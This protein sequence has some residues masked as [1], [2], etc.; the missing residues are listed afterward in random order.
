MIILLALLDDV[1][2]MTIAYDRTPLP[3]RP[4]R[5][6]MRRLLLESGFMGLLSIVQTFGLLIIGMEWV[7]NAQWQAWITLTQE[8]LQT[9]I[10]L[11]LV[12]GGH[13]LLLVVRSRGA[14]YSRPW[15]ARPLLFAVLGTQLVAVLMCGFGWVVTAIPW[16]VIALV[17]VYMIIWML[18]LDLAKRLIHRRLAGDTRDGFAGA[19]VSSRPWRRRR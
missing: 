7:S 11:Q 3:S 19:R 6:R 1:P 18:A 16:T 4:V 13:L 14:F 2:I 15:P 10:F 9:I 12:A 17:W 8:H 5:W